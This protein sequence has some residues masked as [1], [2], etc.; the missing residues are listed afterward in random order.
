MVNGAWLSDTWGV[1]AD[2]ALTLYAL[3]D[4][5]PQPVLFADRRGRLV[6]GNPAACAL[7][8][9]A[10]LDLRGLLHVSDVYH[11]PDDARSVLRAAKSGGTQT[12]RPVD[13]MLRTRSGVVVPARIHAR[14]HSNAAGEVLGTIGVFED[15]REV[16]DLSRRLEEAANQVVASEKRA[17]ALAIAAKT[18]HDLSQPLMAAMGNV[19]LVL[20]QAN[21]NGPNTRHLERAYEQLE[22]LRDIVDDFVRMT[23][24]R[25]AT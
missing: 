6:H 12:D 16:S 5:L 4:V 11:R 20:M 2:P 23:A 10:L 21:L 7:L 3:L 24:R 15:V 8:G 22:R 9:Y 17:A 18:A 1:F 25:G 13:V 14:I 19:E